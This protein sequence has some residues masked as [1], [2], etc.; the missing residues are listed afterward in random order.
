MTLF[1][2]ILIVL[3]IIGGVLVLSSAERTWR[4]KKFIDNNAPSYMPEYWETTNRSIGVG[5]IA[6]GLLL[7]FVVGFVR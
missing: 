5:L 3:S 4:V 7:V 1:L 2:L 6:F